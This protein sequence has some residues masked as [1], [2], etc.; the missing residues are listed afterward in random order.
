VWV[1]ACFR[2]LVGEVEGRLW[3]CRGGMQ[4][5]QLLQDITTHNTFT[6]VKL[7]GLHHAHQPPSRNSS[8][9]QAFVFKSFR[10]T[11]LPRFLMQWVGP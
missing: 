6:L 5:K 2:A 11:C 8:S 10:W 4:I 3:V 1:Q 7:G 9:N